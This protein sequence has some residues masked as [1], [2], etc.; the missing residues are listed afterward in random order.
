MQ[1]MIVVLN[2]HTNL[3][4]CIIVALTFQCLELNGKNKHM[5]VVW[6]RHNHRRQTISRHHE[7]ETMNNKI[8][9]TSTQ[10]KYSNNPFLQE[11]DN[12]KA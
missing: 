1:C 11:R 10:L 12:S 7:E 6:R 8:H 9:T 2:D 4:F 3:L 5:S